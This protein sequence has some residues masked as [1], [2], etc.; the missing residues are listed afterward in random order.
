MFLV[1]GGDKMPPLRENG[2]IARLR[3]AFKERNSGGVSWK[4]LPAEWIRK[5]LNGYS[6]EA[7]NCLIEEHMAIGRA[8]DQVPESREDYRDR[9]QY[10]YDFRIAISGRLIYVETVLIETRMGPIVT[11]VNIHA[12]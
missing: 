12:A 3:L 8:I 4:K 6:Q 5:N 10:H 1:P 7:I 9:F 11:V 2:T